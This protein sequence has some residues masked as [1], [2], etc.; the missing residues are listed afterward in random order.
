MKYL[1]KRCFSYI[2]DIYFITTAHIIL[3]SLFRF[4][5]TGVFRLSLLYVLQN[6]NYVLITVYFL[7][8]LFSEYFFRKTLG[9]KIFRL[10]VISEKNKFSQY[11]IRSFSRLIPIDF[12]FIF[13]TKNQTFHDIISKTK[14]V[15]G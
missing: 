9:K 8:F 7:Y 5:V 15:E 14:V 6:Y 10:K 12:V 2:F 3:F 11:L 13:F 1:I 4:Y